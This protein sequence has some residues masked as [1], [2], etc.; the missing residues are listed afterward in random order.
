M[1]KIKDWLFYIALIIMLSTSLFL[2]YGSKKQEAKLKAS[3]EQKY[4]E[5]KE[6]LI[7]IKS[8]ILTN[9]FAEDFAVNLLDTGF[10]ENMNGEKQSFKTLF[11]KQNHLVLLF[12]ESICPVC[13]ELEVQRLL[14]IGETKKIILLT[15]KTNKRF[16][17]ILQVQYKFSYDILFW[18]KST[19]NISQFES[20]QPLY[21]I[22]DG[23]RNSHFF[24]VDKSEPE[25][26]DSYLK[27]I[28]KHL[29]LKKIVN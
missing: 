6:K 21:F 16:V 29:Q 2:N 20:S 27:Y 25:L 7:K 23:L 15:T 28:S 18:T 14:K 12:R 13:I 24:I 5:I 22:S 9:H 17:K 19:L 26:T 1:N 11:Q 10:I 4:N 8:N 3:Y